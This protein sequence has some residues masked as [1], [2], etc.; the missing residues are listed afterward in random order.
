MTVPTSL[1]LV[2]GLRL[3]VPLALVGEEQRAFLMLR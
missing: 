1:V 3:S 2:G